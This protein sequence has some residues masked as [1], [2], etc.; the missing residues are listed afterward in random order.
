MEGLEILEEI[1]IDY[2]DWEET[3][4]EERWVIRTLKLWFFM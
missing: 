4:P 1:P 3:A 2:D